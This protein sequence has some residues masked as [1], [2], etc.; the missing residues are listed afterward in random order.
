MSAGTSGCGLDGG[1]S[2]ERNSLHEV[3]SKEDLFPMIFVN[4]VDV[5]VIVF[6]LSPKHSD[7][8]WRDQLGLPQ[9]PI[10]LTFFPPLFRPVAL[11]TN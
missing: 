4:Y 8:T 11:V 3:T 10:P 2:T 1:H 5:M 7:S 6:V 9:H